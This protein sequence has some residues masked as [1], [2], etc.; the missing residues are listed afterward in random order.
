M[1]PPDLGRLGI[2][3]VVGLGLALFC[4]SFYYGSVAPTQD[5]LAML[6]LEQA[7]LLKRSAAPSDS[8]EGTKLAKPV[9][10]TEHLPSISTVPE[11]LKKLNDSAAK[12]GVT[13][14]RAS[15]QLSDQDAQRR[16]EVTLPLK[17]SYPA[18]RAYL[19]DALMLA[20]VASLDEVS[21]QRPQ[22]SVP[23]IDATIRVSYYFA[24]SP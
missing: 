10:I 1:T 20:P 9:A 23:L 21:L 17:G 14:E 15:Y 22:A 2:P 12:H 8:G 6:K 24:A 18:L 13:S 19:R 7:Q 5:K 11:L 4:A 16:I 3:G